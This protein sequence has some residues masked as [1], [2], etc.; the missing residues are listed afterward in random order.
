MKLTPK[1]QEICDKYCAPDFDGLVGCTQ[2]PLN[3]DKEPWAW[4]YGDCI[5]YATIDGRVR[6]AR[7]LKR[8]E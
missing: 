6:E 3:L 2:C 1:E 4:N 8:Y 5:C 7:G